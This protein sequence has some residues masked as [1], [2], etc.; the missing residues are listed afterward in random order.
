MRMLVY[1]LFSAIPALFNVMIILGFVFTVFG[2]LGV[3]FWN[4]VL[5]HRCRSTPE[6]VNGVWSLA[7]GGK[8]CG[9]AY[10]CPPGQY[11]G[12]V[13][14]PPKNTYVDLSQL[15]SAEI[16]DYATVGFD[17]IGAAVFTLFQCITLE[18]WTQVM[19]N[20]Q[21]T[22]S[23]TFATFY[24]VV[25][26]IVGAFF[27]L[28]FVFAVIWERF[29]AANDGTAGEWDL[30]LEERRATLVAAAAEPAVEEPPKDPTIEERRAKFR[31]K[32]SFGGAVRSLN[33]G[34]VVVKHN[35]VMRRLRSHCR[36]LVQNNF[37]S[38]F[39]VF[40]ILLN[41]VS[42][43]M[44]EYP[45]DR[46]RQQISETANTVLT[47]VF[48][49]EM[50]L[51]LLGLGW[52]GYIQDRFNLFD[53]VVVIVSLIEL[54]LDDFSA[55]N[56]P[57]TGLSALRSF[58]LFRIMKLA[59][60]WKS[61]RE[62][63]ETIANSIA[64]V[65]NFGLLLLLLILQLSLDNP[66]DDPDSTL[67][68]ILEN[69]DDV[70][71]GVF[72]VE[73]V[74]KVVDQGFLLNG[75]TSYLRDGWNI[76]DFVII[77]CSSIT[78]FSSSKT[79]RSLRSLRTLR[80]LRPLRMIS[81]IPGMRRVVN[82]LLSSIP[83]I[84]NVFLVCILIFLIFG[85][86]GVNIFKGRLFYCDMSSFSEDQMRR[87][88]ME[89]GFTKLS[90]KKLFSKDNCLSEGGQWMR[91]S[92]NYDN[93]LKSA[94]T[95]FEISTTEGWTGI[96]YQGIDATKIGFHPVENWDRSYI[97]FFVAF[98]I[99]GSFF[100]LNLF[101]G[102][103]IDNFNRMRDSIGE[104]EVENDTE[105]EWLQ[106][107]N[108]LKNTVS[109]ML[110]L[111]TDNKI[112]PV[113]NTLRAFRMGL[114]IR[115]MKKAK[116]MQDI[117]MTI[118]DNMPA[119]VNVSTV[120]FL[121]MFVYA[122]IGVQL[123]AGVM[124]GDNL[125]EHAN[126][127]NVPTAMVTLFRFATGEAWNDVMYDLMVEPISG[128]AE[129]PDGPSCVNDYSYAKLAAVRNVSGNPDLT[130]GCTPGRTVTYAYFMSYQLVATYVL[131]N[132]FVAVILE[133][134]E[135]TTEKNQSAVTKDDLAHICFLW[136]RY[137]PSARGSISDHE[138]LKFLRDVPP[139]LGL[140]KNSRRRDVERW[141]K[142]LNLQLDVNGRV[143]F[144]AFLL[145]A[146]QLAMIKVA[147]ERGDRISPARGVDSFFA[148]SHNVVRNMARSR[149]SITT[150]PDLFSI[151][152]AKRIQSVIRSRLA[153][154]R[155]QALRQ[156]ILAERMQLYDEAATSSRDRDPQGHHAGSLPGDTTPSE[157]QATTDST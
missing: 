115:L 75:K 126:F 77:I 145:A 151:I 29:N 5:Y 46:T 1:A 15:P 63:L 149:A 147:A 65:A 59:R 57:N 98:I 67:S 37:F 61:L 43:A 34:L 64:D 90:F 144:N 18:G 11:C 140:P 33:N 101:V 47:I 156:L 45:P 51:K 68:K 16:W 56:S 36:D 132:L 8:L 10:S 48:S 143:T 157:Q 120:M 131:L 71:T 133:G 87:L 72:Y 39:I 2:I 86:I 121:I 66:L 108:L 35:T 14:D 9:G 30:I 134:F 49:L 154:K 130:I 135:E 6:P 17:N 80:A 129:V 19:Y 50:F 53:G 60:S 70:F 41:T 79:L 52:R 82:A 40:C 105:R 25:F 7:D 88:E 141:A 116:S 153:R 152:A 22:H 62:L 4:G 83:S 20:M 13:Y 93:V 42:L 44:D 155:M 110:P 139:P 99:M 84:M 137:D 21:D 117:V 73:M 74:L 76:V 102:A 103:V 55:R 109:I 91:R 94:M 113:A 150:G 148:K 85:I 32:S 104:Q 96:M 123:Y 114:A 124:L 54:L 3:L 125:N 128:A 107:Q 26:T 81:R 118:L 24:F 122:V 97:A 12:S 89:Y 28:Q 95:L 69:F 78:M 138:F 27:L 92:R 119:L 146:A 23:Y 112:S 38:S 106:I 142:A 58:R 127:R 111:F 31:K 136:E 100:T